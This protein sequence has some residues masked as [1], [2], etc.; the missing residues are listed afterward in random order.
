MPVMGINLESWLGLSPVTEGGVES[1]SPTHMILEM[2]SELGVIFLLFTVGLETKVKDL[3]A[4][5]RTAFLVALLGV[6]VPFF[7]GYAYVTMVDSNIY[8]AMF[9]GAAMVALA[10]CT[11]AAAIWAVA[12]VEI[13]GWK[14]V[15]VVPTLLLTL[16]LWACLMFCSHWAERI[17]RDH[18]L[19]TYREV[20]DFWNGVEPNRDT[21]RGRRERA[22]PGWMRAVRSVGMVILAA[23][24][25]YLCARYGVQLLQGLLG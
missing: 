5:G 9:M 6:L 19:A 8:H 10:A 20:L 23:A 14:G 18:D 11:V 17:K 2:F 25:G 4:V 24:V 3:T 7:V 12:Q 16:V 22:I 13:W 21:E 1:E 15:Q